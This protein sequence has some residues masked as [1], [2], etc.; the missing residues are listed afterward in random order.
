M[1]DDSGGVYVPLR[2]FGAPANPQTPVILLQP[3]AMP[4]EIYVH[5]LFYVRN[6]FFLDGADL[7]HP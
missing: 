7:F 2:G 4:A 1:T 5:Y 6:M 3:A